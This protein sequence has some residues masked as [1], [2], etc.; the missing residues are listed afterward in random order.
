[1][2][3]H[4]ARTAESLILISPGLGFSVLVRTIARRPRLLVALPFAAVSE[5]ISLVGALADTL[6]SGQ[7][8]AVWKRYGD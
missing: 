2:V 5:L 3:G 4:L 6:S 7:K 8:H 1:M